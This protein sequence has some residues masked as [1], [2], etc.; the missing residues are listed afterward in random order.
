MSSPW[1]CRPARGS[2]VA[3]A[4]LAALAGCKK[5]PELQPPEPPGVTV[6][7]PAERAFAPY[8]EFTGRIEAKDPV[9]VV[10]QVT[11]VLLSRDFVEGKAVEKD[12]S[13]MYRIDPIL[14]QAD[15]DSAVANLAKAE[16]DIIKAKADTA[17]AK[18]Q[19]DRELAAFNMGGG[20]ASN[21]DERAA[22]Y[23]VAK[24]QMKVTESA[25][26][27]AE[28]AKAKAQKNLDY[29][30]IKAPTTG[31][32]RLSRVAVGDAVSAYQTVLDEIIPT[33]KVY[34]T[35]EVDELTSLW[36]RD[37]IYDKKTIPDPKKTA[38]RVGIAQKNED[39]FTRFSTV[40]FVDT[41]IVRG[42]GTRT[43]RAEFDNRDDKLSPGD[44]VRVRVDAGAAGK[45]LMIPETVVVQ[46][47]RQRVV[48]VIDEKDEVV[49]HPVELGQ[50]D[51]G[52]VVV[53]GGVTAA[54][55]VAAS[56]LLR[57]RPGVKVRVQQ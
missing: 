30:T 57:L 41:E 6:V 37:E 2:A 20:S 56:N 16:A 49:V 19:Y 53:R 28:A 38:L 54:D 25:R 18:V 39:K 3:L 34:A 22:Q 47:D 1:S 9:R 40:S 35:W 11:G 26:Q 52:W 17:L 31:V 36:Y 46:Q 14:F 21:K 29:C 42:T 12:K 24:A 45:A 15:Y 4:A 48:Y 33:E 43:I 51:G 5:P 8:K 10:P 55:R 44:S 23:E 32:T 50:S 27:A 13:V 7:R